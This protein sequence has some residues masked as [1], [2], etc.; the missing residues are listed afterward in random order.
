MVAHSFKFYKIL[1]FLH[2]FA[3]F[4]QL[5]TFC[6][7]LHTF[8]HFSQLCI[9]CS[10]KHLLDQRILQL[11]ELVYF[12]ITIFSTFLPRCHQ[13][14]MTTQF[15]ALEPC[16]VLAAPN[17]FTYMHIM[18]FL[19]GEVGKLQ[20]WPDKMLHVAYFTQLI[21][22]MLWHFISLLIVFVY[23]CM[24]VFVFARM[25]PQNIIRSF[26]DLCDNL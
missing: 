8:A 18:Y 4:A 24:C 23:L 11:L 20:S 2:T 9:F 22:F 21:L 15:P 13:S 7:M 12:I 14:S 17:D 5:C 10:N 3:H 19:Q 1:H 16:T 6:T 25:T 26:V